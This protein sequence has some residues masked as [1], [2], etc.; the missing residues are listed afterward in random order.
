MRD[1]Y[2]NF[3]DLNEEAQNYILE[4]AADEIRQDADQIR[5]IISTYG[6][7]SLDEIIRERAERNIYEYNYIFNV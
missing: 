7:A 1:I 3:S 5:E 4:M 2:I 6:R